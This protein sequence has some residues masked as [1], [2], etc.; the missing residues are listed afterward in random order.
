MYET[1]KPEPGSEQLKTF[2][3]LTGL[4]DRRSFNEALHLCEE[5]IPGKFTIAF[6]DLD[7]LKKINDTEGHVKGDE[8]IQGAAHAMSDVLRATDLIA[9]T[10]ASESGRIG[11][12]EIG[13]I[14]KDV[15]KPED[16]NEIVTRVR[17]GF[18]E[19]GIKA[20]IGTASHQLEENSSETLHRADEAMK[21]D[22]EERKKKELEAKSRLQRL[23][24]GGAKILLKGAGVYDPR[25]HG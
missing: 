16:I 12:D 18:K 11:G 5:N 14:L 22:K 24:M 6:I 2:D 15:S 3:S 13:V 21:R 19:K 9:L 7:G 1:Q 10:Q 8:Y 25:I 23:M 4:L 20:S 17:E